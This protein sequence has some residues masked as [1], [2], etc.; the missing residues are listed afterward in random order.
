MNQLLIAPNI[1]FYSFVQ[2]KSFSKGKKSNFYMAVN[3]I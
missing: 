2:L 1:T 3:N